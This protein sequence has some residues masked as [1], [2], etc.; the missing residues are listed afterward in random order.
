MHLTNILGARRLG[1]AAGS[2]A[3][4]AAGVASVS[5]AGAALTATVAGDTLTVKGSAANDGVALRLAPGQSGTLQ[6]DFGDDG[7][8]DASFDRATFSSIRVTLRSGAD[9]FRVDQ[10]NGTFAD[11]ALTVEGEG[12][13]DTMN[14]GDGVEQFFGGAGNDVVDGN[15]GNDTGTLGSGRDSFRWDPGDGSDVVE[16][17]LGFDTL[18]FNG[19]AA[20]EI[21]SLSANGSR[22]LFLRDVANIRMDMDDVEALDLTALG[23]VDT[24]TVNDM[25]G[26]DFQRAGVDLSGPAGGP[27]GAADVVTVNGSARGDAIAATAAGTGIE[28]TGLKTTTAIAGSEPADQLR[29]DGQAGNDT[30]DVDPAVNALIT[31]VATP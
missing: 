26:T 25:S 9:S 22:S 13:N 24:M 14:G 18:D 27:D 8:A 21:M 3:F 19:A 15:R 5:P 20:D 31:V 1:L 12:G 10:V 23:G 6:V 29:I 16:G 17:G 30:I 28:V 2:L 4:V 11:E 7:T